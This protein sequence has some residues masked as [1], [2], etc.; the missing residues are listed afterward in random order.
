MNPTAWITPPQVTVPPEDI[1]GRK[2]AQQAYDMDDWERT[3]SRRNEQTEEEAEHI[4][5]DFLNLQLEQDRI[6]APALQTP[7]RR[8]KLILLMETLGEP[9]LWLQIPDMVPALVDDELISHLKK[10][11]ALRRLNEEEAA[12]LLLEQILSAVRA[13]IQFWDHCL[14]RSF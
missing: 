3:K 10:K 6:L 5:D 8:S 13:Q 14:N 12:A 1:E 11:L 9:Q 7:S 2:A 4:V